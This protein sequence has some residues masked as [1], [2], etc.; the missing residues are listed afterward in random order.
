MSAPTSEVRASGL[1]LPA[2]LSEARA[3]LRSPALLVMTGMTPKET[4][5]ALQGNPSFPRSQSSD[6][7][8][9][10]PQSCKT[11]VRLGPSSEVDE[12]MLPEAGF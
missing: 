12:H 2:H 7:P 6:K 11:L 5:A 3:P 10:D 4:E 8:G 1:W 9:L